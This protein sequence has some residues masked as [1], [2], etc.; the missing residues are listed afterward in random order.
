MQNLDLVELKAGNNQHASDYIVVNYYTDGL[1]IRFRSVVGTLTAEQAE[2]LKRGLEVALD[3][4]DDE[5]KVSRG[6]PADWADHVAEL[7]K[8]D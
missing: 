8:E 5:R 7:E 6:T 2:H 4:L 3:M 1:E